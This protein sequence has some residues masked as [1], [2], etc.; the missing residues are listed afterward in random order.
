MGAKMENGKSTVFGKT[1]S[2][3]AAIAL[4]A[5]GPSF[6]AVTASRVS[7]DSTPSE[8]G[9]A[10]KADYA[11]ELTG[12]LAGCW[13]TFVSHYN[14]EA[15]NGYSL[16]TEIGREEFEGKLEGEAVRFDTVYSFTGIFPEGSCPS[17]AADKEITGGCIHY[18]SG[19]GLV[20]TIRFYDVM[21][22]EG[23]PHYFY[24]GFLSRN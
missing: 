21:Q 24:E 14:C 19:D 5:A 1:L 6:S 17:P 8:C 4:A 13:S 9:S 3:A 20:G 18:I 2:L 16:Y 11:I 22:G 23:A 7:G 12:S 10:K 15:M